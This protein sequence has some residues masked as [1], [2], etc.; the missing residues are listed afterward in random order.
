MAMALWRIELNGN[1]RLARGTVE[2]GPQT[3]L[4]A[5]TTLAQLLNCDAAAFA[6]AL[7]G[8]DGEAVPSDRKLLAPV[9]EQ[10]VWAAGVTYERS[11]E[12]RR[13]ESKLPDQYERVYD[14]ER[15]EIFFKSAGRR[16]RGTDQPLGIRADSTWDVPE[17][18]LGLVVNSHGDIVGYTI[19]NDMSSRSIE[20]EN[21]LYL[22]QA[23]YYTGSCAIGPCVVPTNEAT[24]I[25]NMIIGLNIARNGKLIF[26]DKISVARMKRT[27]NELVDWLFRAQEFPEGVVLLTGT[28]LV[29]SSDFT[30]LPGDEV[31]ITITG[32]GELRNRIERVGRFGRL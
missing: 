26:D 6:A 5:E 1:I 12:A 20:G 25:H 21:A 19:C 23:K 7:H 14:A 27:P 10:E 15:P 17:P 31:L 24:A 29:P 9:A 4:S 11:R 28:G 2:G 30:L 22:P 8:S 32:L 13:E 16:V 18:E 3:L